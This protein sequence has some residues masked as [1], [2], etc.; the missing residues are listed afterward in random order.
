MVKTIESRNFGAVMLEISKNTDIMHD[1]LEEMYPEI[2][3][4][5]ANDEDTPTWYHA[6]NGPQNKSHWQ[7]MTTEIRTLT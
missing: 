1:T 5:K 7:A 6:M 2:L 3:S 4:A